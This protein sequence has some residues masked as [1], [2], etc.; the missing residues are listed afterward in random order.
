MKEQNKYSLVYNYKTKNVF[1]VI[2]TILNS[3]NNTFLIKIN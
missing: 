3:M 1:R 2:T